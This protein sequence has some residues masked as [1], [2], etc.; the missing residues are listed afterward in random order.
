MLGL[1]YMEIKDIL[2]GEQKKYYLA[3]REATNHHE[4]SYNFAAWQALRKLDK[5]I[6]K[7]IKKRAKR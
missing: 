4:K 7:E 1:N 2:T 5:K 6:I 3:Y